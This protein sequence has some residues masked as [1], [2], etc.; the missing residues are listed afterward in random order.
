MNLNKLSAIGSLLAIIVTTII[1]IATWIDYKF[2][3]LAESRIKPYEILLLANSQFAMKQYEEA[4]LSYR[5]VFERLLDNNAESE[6]L[7]A[8]YIPAINALAMLDNPNKY[9]H[10]LDYFQQHIKDKLTPDSITR[11]NLGWIYLL[12]N[13]PKLAIQN[14]DTSIRLY[15]LNGDYALSDD[16]HYGLALSYFAVGE[17]NNGAEYYFRANN[18]DPASYSFDDA[19]NTPVTNYGYGQNLLKIYPSFETTYNAFVYF[20]VND[21]GV[22]KFEYI[23]IEQHEQRLREIDQLLQKAS[24]IKK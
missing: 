1:S 6:R 22:E 14:F 13:Q 10:L 8:I 24:S 12:T 11:E 4:L 15:E 21:K 3:K 16:A 18:I 7:A 17:F 20:L 2:E 23:P 5:E 9:L 19:V